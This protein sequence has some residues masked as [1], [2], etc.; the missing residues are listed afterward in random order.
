M[1]LR[2][3]GDRPRHPWELARSR[4]LLA[5][6]QHYGVLPAVGS[7]LDGGAGDGWLAR[8]LLER[9]PAAARVTCWDA[10]YTPDVMEP[11]VAAGNGRVQCVSDRPTARFDLVTLL[12]VAEHVADDHGFM[13]AVVGDNLN[14]GGH[15]L[16]TV[17]AWQPLFTS[18]DTFLQHH[19]RYAPAQAQQLLQQSGLTLVASGGLFHSLL[20]PRFA[21]KVREITLGAPSSQQP[22][23]A[24]SGGKWVTAAVGSAL[25]ID[26]AVSARAASLG[27]KLPG[28]SYWALCRKP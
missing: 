10:E 13:A 28:L 20:V 8:Q 9:L 27:L 7:V 15:L 12:D 21:Q 17:P 22:G 26:N 1:D 14:V 25:A 11:I 23:I 5:T 4:F 18:H 3:T 24:W 16:F 19:R 6:L 2:E